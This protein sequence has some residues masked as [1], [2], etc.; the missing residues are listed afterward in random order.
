MGNFRV[1]NVN[2]EAY[3]KVGAATFHIYGVERVV[4]ALAQLRA[5][6][7]SLVL[8]RSAASTL[9]PSRAQ[10]PSLVLRRSV[11][12]T[13]QKLRAIDASLGI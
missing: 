4:A 11:A 5:Q 8:R 2:G 1:I 10:S 7:S 13:L 6:S 9:T 12:S 3:L